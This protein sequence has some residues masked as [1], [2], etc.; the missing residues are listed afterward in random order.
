MVIIA[1]AVAVAIATTAAVT[2][3]VTAGTA[4]VGWVRGTA[5]RGVLWRVMM[6]APFLHGFRS[7]R[8]TCH[9]R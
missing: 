9:F 3:M 7:F 1:V 6:M 2:M 4:V 8:S 5:G